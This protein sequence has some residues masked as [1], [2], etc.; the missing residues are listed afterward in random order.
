MGCRAQGG[1][2]M[3]CLRSRLQHGH[4]AL[5]HEALPTRV[6]CMASM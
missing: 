6:Q 3:A 1:M 4:G 5:M 2:F